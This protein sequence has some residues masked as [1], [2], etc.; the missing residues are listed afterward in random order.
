MEE[1][2]LWIKPYAS[3]EEI[4][5]ALDTI[6]DSCESIIRRTAG[7]SKME[8]F[9]NDDMM[10]ASA[11]DMQIIGNHAGRLPE[12][13]RSKSANLEDAYG[14]RCRI[15]HDYGGVRFETDYLWSA[16]SRDV[17]N[18]LDTCIAARA[19]LLSE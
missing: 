17:Y 1:N 7:V 16:V 10:K 6:I 9:G 3:R 13:I 18:I 5:Y 2:Q 4:L 19:E 14:F 15:A 11:M 12:H 8:F